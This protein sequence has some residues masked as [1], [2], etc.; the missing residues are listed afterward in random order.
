M[1][2]NPLSSLLPVTLQT[3]TGISRTSP[4]PFSTNQTEASA[5]TPSISPAASFLSML[6]QVQQSNPGLFKQITQ[7]IAKQFQAHA[8]AAANQGDATR[9]N[10]LKQLATEFQNSSS[11][12]ELPSA[13]ALQESGFGTH[14]GHHGHHHGGAPPVNDPQTLLNNLLGITST[15][16]S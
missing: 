12:G 1:T 7:Q 10:Q 2:I 14:H 13:Q 3:G 11:T 9:A 8:T 5:D 4:N 16:S 15:T 6:Q